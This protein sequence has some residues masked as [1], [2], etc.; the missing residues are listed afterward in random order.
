MHLSIRIIAI[1]GLF[2]LSACDGSGSG[3]SLS[4]PTSAPSNFSSTAHDG[5]VRLNWDEVDDA[6]GYNL[7][8]A[9]ESITDISNYASFANGTKVMGVSS[10]YSVIGLT[11]GTEYFFV[12]T[13]TNNAGESIPSSELAA[14]PVMPVHG[15]TM[16]ELNDSGID[17]CI[18]P[19]GTDAEKQAG[20]ED[21]AES[22]PNQD[23]MLGRDAE[24]RAGTLAKVGDGVAGFD[25]SRVCNSGEIAGEG[26]CPVEPQLGSNADDWGCTRDNVTGLIW[27]V[28]VKVD[29]DDPEHLRDMDHTYSWY[30]TDGATNGGRVGTENAGDCTGS[31]CDTQGFVQAVNSLTGDERLCGANDWRMPSYVELQS[32]VD[33]GR[34]SPAIDTAY[35]PNTPFSSTTIS[36]AR[37]WSGTTPRFSAG[38]AV[39]IGFRWGT[40]NASSKLQDI[41][42]IRL[43]RFEQ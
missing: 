20:C 41:R 27:E 23:G 9:T 40:V 10:P 35:F 11:N 6:T 28:K 15:F 7:Y 31:A 13:A 3:S 14:T 25:F 37:I 21:R 2:F 1:L 5:R 32:I 33:Y 34:H 42:R 22:Y 17:W 4:P 19:D 36:P 24:A 29:V 18:D 12:V 39:D 16:L 30:D 38:A 26:S 43:V 8:F